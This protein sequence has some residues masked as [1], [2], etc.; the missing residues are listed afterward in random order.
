MKVDRRL[1]TKMSFLDLYGPV[2]SSWSSSGKVHKSGGGGGG[3]DDEKSLDLNA[4]EMQEMVDGKFCMLFVPL[5]YSLISRIDFA[6]SDKKKQLVL[7][8]MQL[9]LIKGFIL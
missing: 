1:T 6:Y 2:L 4:G 3:G 7:R 5:F 9:T 8:S